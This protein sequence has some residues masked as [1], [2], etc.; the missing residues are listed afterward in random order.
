LFVVFLLICIPYG[1]K[2]RII[3][4]ESMSFKDIA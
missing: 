1:K 3:G 4:V 2:K